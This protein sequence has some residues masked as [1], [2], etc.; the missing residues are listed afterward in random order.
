M[1]Q[2]PVRGNYDSTMPYLW[3]TPDA[4]WNGWR[5][6]EEY[7]RIIDPQSGRLWTAN[8][9]TV[10]VE[11]WL[12]FMGDGMYDNGARAAQIRD[13]L[14]ALESATPTDMVNIQLDD[15]ALFLIRWRDFLLELLD[16][17]SPCGPSRCERK[18]ENSWKIGR[19]ARRPRMSAI[20]WFAPCGCEFARMFSNR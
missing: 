4:G 19:L 8:A 3:N 18:P 1:G 10:D 11:T 7:P 20:A 17:E 12:S 14:L 2:V 6:P 13:D 15:R 5:K 9:R 16:E